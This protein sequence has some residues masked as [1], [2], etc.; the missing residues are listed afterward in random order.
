MI[1]TLEMG[2]LVFDQQSFR[3]LI[4]SWGKRYSNLDMDMIFNVC[5]S[6]NVETMFGIN[7]MNNDFEV[8]SI[9]QWNMPMIFNNEISKTK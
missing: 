1:D 4:C 7:Y 2:D 9:K 3:I 5:S 6:T 8:E